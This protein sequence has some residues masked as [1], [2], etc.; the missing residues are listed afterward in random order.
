[1][2]IVYFSLMFFVLPMFNTSCASIV[3][4]PNKDLV[5][6]LPY[7]KFDQT[8]REGWRFLGEVEK[9]YLAA[10]KLIDKYINR[11]IASLKEWQLRILHWHAGQMY[12]FSDEIIIARQR[13]V[14]SID[15]NKSKDTPILWNDYVLATIAF[16]DKDLE[17]LKY[18][19]QIIF[20]G[21]MLNGIIANLDVVDRLIMCFHKTYKEAYSQCR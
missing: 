13:F 10:A 14:G 7:E 17:K 19:Q 20:N 12:A 21:P 6:N 1:M 15:K 9:N 5:M 2:L 8:P 11:N 18:H 4:K 16:L 3:V